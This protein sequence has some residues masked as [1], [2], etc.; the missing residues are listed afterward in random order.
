MKKKLIVCLFGLATI[1]L[2]IS[3]FIPKFESLVKYYSEFQE[4]FICF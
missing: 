3:I 1:G 4:V 2:A